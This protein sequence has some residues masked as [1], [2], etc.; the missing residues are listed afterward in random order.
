MTLDQISEINA[1]ALLAEGFNNAIMGMSIQ[2]G[3]LPVVAY[4]Y[5]ECLKILQDRD[6]MS[7]DEATEYMEFN[8]IGSYM[9]I[10]SPVFIMK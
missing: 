5:E 3:Q 8:V 6:D 10:N 9:G 4:D 2:F 7:T 1:E